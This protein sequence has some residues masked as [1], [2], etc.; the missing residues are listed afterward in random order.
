MVHNAFPA[1]FSS[2]AYAKE[3]FWEAMTRVNRERAE[4]A[5]RSGVQPG[6]EYAQVDRPRGNERG[7]D[8]RESKV[9]IS[10]RYFSH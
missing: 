10:L 2:L 3:A 9:M 5:S 4:Y 6:E 1:Y 8:H 7:R